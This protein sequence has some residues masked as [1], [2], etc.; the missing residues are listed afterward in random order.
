MKKSIFIKQAELILRILPLIDKEQIFALKG[1][2][3]INYFVREMPRL[4]VDIDLMYLPVS[5]REETLANINQALNR[6]E[7]GIRDSFYNINITE[8]R[9]ETNYVTKLIVRQNGAT[10]K[11][12]PNLV[13]RGNIYPVE[14]R[15]LVKKAQD[16]F[17]LYVKVRTLSTAELYGGK[18]C[19]ALDRQ[20][21]RDFFDIKIL[22]EHEGFT[23]KIKKAFIVYLISHNRPMVELLN[24]K[25]LN[26]RNVFNNELRGMIREDV[27]YEK[28]VKIREDLVKIIKSSLTFEEKRFIVSIQEGEPEWELLG[29][30]KIEQLPA[31]K[32]KLLNVRKMSHVKRKEAVK[33]LEDYFEL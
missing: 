32:W 14:S 12:E 26:F 10:V 3:A 4:S 15:E 25:F 31:V 20:H 19:A 24:P 29:L 6:I 9:S 13:L 5:G 23:E 11:I 22:F 30:K 8:S 16:L 1:G 17:E 33:K 7:D 18:I 21:P 2:T 28:L 27:E